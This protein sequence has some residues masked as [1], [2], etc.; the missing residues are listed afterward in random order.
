MTHLAQEA[1]EAMSEALQPEALADATSSS[2]A[3]AAAE[4]AAAGGAGGAGADQQQLR[5][6]SPTPGG[7]G[8]AAK[9]KVGF[10]FCVNV[11]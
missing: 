8:E 6:T 1:D 7:I 5:S 2:S 10:V 11:T 9:Y 3:V 4:A